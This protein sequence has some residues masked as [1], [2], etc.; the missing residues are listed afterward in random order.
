MASRA[1]ACRQVPLRE[2]GGLVA[3]AS[4]RIVSAATGRRE[5]TDARWVRLSAVP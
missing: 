1:K 3:D 5:G 4:D 2:S